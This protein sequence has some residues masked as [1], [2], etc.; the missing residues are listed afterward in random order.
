MA[1]KVKTGDKISIAKDAGWYSLFS[2]MTKREQ[3]IYIEHDFYDFLLTII[4]S[5][6]KY[7]IITESAKKFKRYLKFLELYLS[8]DG[9]A[10]FF[11]IDNRLIVSQCNFTGDPDEYGVGKDLIAVTK[12]GVSHE[13]KNWQDNK[14]VVVIFNNLYHSSDYLIPSTASLLKNADISLFANI[15]ATRHTSLIPVSDNTEKTQMEA[16]VKANELGVPQVVVSKSKILE[17]FKS[18]LEAINLTDMKQSDK[19]QYLSKLRDDLMRFFYNIYGMSTYGT[20]KMAQQNSD[21]INSGL[22]ASFIVPESRLEAR[23][24]GLEELKEKFGIEIEVD[25]SLCWEYSFD[26]IVALAAADGDIGISDEEVIND[27]NESEEQAEAPE[28]G[29]TGTDVRESEAG[30]S[31]ESGSGDVISDD[32]E[33]AEAAEELSEEPEA[34]ESEEDSADSEEQ[35]EE[36]ENDSESIEQTV[37]VEINIDG[38]ESDESVNVDN[39][40]SA[41]PDDAE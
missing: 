25:F 3:N 4:T 8:T 28:D 9:H 18:K 29:E 38:G 32:G 34:A 26:R 27:E 14:D 37:E 30:E 40:D 39:R 12:D 20:A 31:E 1:K 36:P 19:L 5:M 17:E 33:S 22:C 23:R 41:D 6:F 15:N 16:A 35:Q 10:C 11:M 21:E 7:T 2:D 13:F 24:E